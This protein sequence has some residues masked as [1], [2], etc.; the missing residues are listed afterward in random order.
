MIFLRS[1]RQETRDCLDDGEDDRGWGKVR[2]MEEEGDVAIW[3][4][5]ISM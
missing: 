5:L 4:L 1:K 3:G 2:Q